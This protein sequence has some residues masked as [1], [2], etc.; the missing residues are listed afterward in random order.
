[1]T[2]ASSPQPRTLRPIADVAADLGVPAEA[3]HPY[4]RYAAKID[5]WTHALPPAGGDGRRPARVILVTSINPTPAGE[6]KTV[7]SISLAM[8]LRRLGRRAVVALREPSM[9]PVFGLKGGATGGGAATVEPAVDINLHFTGDL[10]AV[11]A[12]N[13]LLAS[14]ID[15]HLFRGREPALDVRRITFHRVLDVNDRA[16]RSVVVGLD[17][18]VPR[19]ERFDITAA[20]E[21]MAILGLSR[22]PADLRRRLGRIVVGSGRDRR[23]VTAG[24]LGADGAMA[25]LL[26]TA[27]MPNLV[28]TSEGGPALVHTGP[29]ANIA[30]GTTSLASL[31]LARSLAEFVVVEAGFGADLGAEKFVNL[32]G[33]HGGPQPDA[34][35]VVVTVRALKHHGGAE[36]DLARPDP[37]AVRRGL[38]NLERHVGIV[39]RLGLRPVLAVNRFPSDSPAEIDAVLDAAAAWSVPAACS[40]GY[41]DGGAGAV[42]LAELVIEAADTPA[43]HQP[44]PQVYRPEDPI[45]NKILAVATEIYGA[46][47][48]EFTPAARRSIAWAEDQGFGSLPICVAKTQY[49]LSDDP[50][51]RGAPRGFT[52]TVR[53]VEVRAG[54]G[55]L[56]VLMGDIMT[57]PGLP[58]EPNA[59]RIDVDEQG[60]VRG[61]V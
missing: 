47:G 25:A 16:L 29:F 27:L 5:P 39:R 37:D 13:N 55:F 22:D 53:D 36:G 42:G 26:R 45:A 23:P 61:V 2:D 57:M 35:V 40:T 6:G 21:V 34:A 59:L 52:M 15:N 12:A 4:G 3:L 8:A 7:T 9:G 41:A 14:L 56:V 33:A 51:L 17:G 24:D 20:S 54:A 60:R 10:H 31:A 43:V 28:Q 11:T 44:A 1:M 38:A 30:H 50:G 19:Q 49:S 32:V 46:G 18:A 48:V 58:A